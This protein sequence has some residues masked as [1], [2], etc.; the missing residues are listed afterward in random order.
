L[1]DFAVSFSAAAE[2]D[3]IAIYDY[4]AERAGAEVAFNYVSRIET[5]CLGFNVAPER[6][7]R[8]NDLGQG[9]R[10]VGFER[11]ATILFQVAAKPR[12][13]TVLGIY[14]RGRS[15]EPE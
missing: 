6:G 1:K 15:F 9:L 13:V 8:R 12:T 14:Y 7:S 2:A 4:V 5:Y 3:L 10:T 11:S